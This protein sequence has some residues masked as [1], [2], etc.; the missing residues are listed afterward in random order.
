MQLNGTTKSLVANHL[1]ESI[2]RSMTIRAFEEEDRF[3]VK[4]LDL[5]DVNA[6]PFFH[7]FAANEWLIQQLETLTAV[8]LSSSVHGFAPFG[9]FQLWIYWNGLVLWSLIEHVL[10][11]VHSKPM[12]SSKLHNFCGKAQPIYAH[13]K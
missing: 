8:V 1:A 11:Y 2:A 3:F 7:S 12:H 4:N 5:I 10:C 9:N 13:T 6:T